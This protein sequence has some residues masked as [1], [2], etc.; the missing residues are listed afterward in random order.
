V[1]PAPR[2]SPKLAWCIKWLA[3]VG[4]PAYFDDMGGYAAG[5][6]AGREDLLRRLQAAVPETQRVLPGAD[7]TMPVNVLW[8]ADDPQGTARGNTV[9]SLLTGWT[10]YNT[11]LIDLHTQ[12]ASRPTGV[13]AG[14]MQDFVGKQVEFTD[15]YAELNA[16][17]TVSRARVL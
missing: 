4:D 1:P 13:S 9:R 16:R 3:L 6:R 8:G 7:G 10:A 5:M 11:R 17:S 2:F 15:N 14:S 12:D